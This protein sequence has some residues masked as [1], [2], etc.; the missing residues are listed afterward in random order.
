MLAG[1]VVVVLELKGK[2]A[3]SRA[4]LDQPAAYARDL[5]AYH[6]ECHAREQRDGTIVFAPRMAELDETWEHLRP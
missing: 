2:D 4:D 1:G 3:P 5:R 6:R